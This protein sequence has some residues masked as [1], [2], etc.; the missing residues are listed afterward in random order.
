LAIIEAS[1]YD[2]PSFHI[3]LAD[4]TRSLCVGDATDL[5]N[6]VGPLISPPTGNLL[7]ALTTLEH[8]E[9]WLV[10]P[11]KINEGTYTPGIRKDV[12]PNS[13]FHLTECFGPVLGLMRANDLTHALQ[14][15]NATEYGLTGG[16]QSLDPSEIEYW[17]A[18]AQVG[19]AYVNR[20]IT[21]A[22]VERQP[23]GGWKKSSIGPGSKPG[24]PNHLSGYGN[25]TDQNIDVHQGIADY[26]T[27]WNE[28]F[29]KEHDAAGLRSEANI[30]RYFP[31][32]KVFVRCS[33]PTVP[34]IDLL[35]AASALTGVPLEISVDSDESEVALGNRM[36]QSRGEV[37]LRVLTPAT[38][39][40]YE[41]ANK[42]GA[43]IDT[44]PVT[45]S[46]RLELT[47]WVKEQSISRTMHRYGR[48][49]NQG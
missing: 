26:S 14:F 38:V 11:L 32:D 5:N 9:S 31:A 1:V 44:A 46:G 3:R 21:G 49:L 30:L 35:R 18:N 42:A 25:W 28:Y 47:H 16:I 36:Q 17:L 4:A 15:Q 24:G 41:L 48:L 33:D 8:G 40:L 27:Q 7:R 23:F 10:E 2:D 39:D 12:K 37:R 45:G 29:T 19:N 13:W 22:I 43:T 6:V 34:Q 20:H